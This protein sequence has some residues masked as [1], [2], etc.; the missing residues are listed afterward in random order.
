MLFH[1]LL[2]AKN[3]GNVYYFLQYRSIAQKGALAL[4]AMSNSMAPR[5]MG[6]NTL[7]SHLIVP[8]I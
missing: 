1:L 8:H 4:L 2:P 3:H 6:T 7:A 5:V